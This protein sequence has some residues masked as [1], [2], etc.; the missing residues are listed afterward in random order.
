MPFQLSSD[1]VTRL[2]LVRYL[3]QHAEAVLK[4]PQPLCS[5]ALLSA[6][7]AIEMSLD[8]LAEAAN[9]STATGKN[10]ESYWK[11]LKS[12]A[13][14]VHLPLERQM[15]R[16]NR[17]RVDLKH[18]GLRPSSDQLIT[19]LHNGRA[20]IEDMCDKNF[21]ISLSDICLIDLIKNERL[22][23]MLRD[24]QQAIDRDDLREA[25][26]KAA[27]ALRYSSA[28]DSQSFPIEDN[29]LNRILR[30]IDDTFAEVF[31]R[32][33]VAISLVA[34]GIDLPSYNKFKRLTPLLGITASGKVDHVWPRTPS[35]KPEDARW[36]IDFVIDL[37][38][39][40]E[41]RRSEV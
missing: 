30:E 3:L 9:A 25:F 31:G 16:L 28:E 26:T 37:V 14:L 1:Q 12:S 36:C 23:D 39:R 7:D 2:A 11:G 32:M 10:F 40:V 22:R 19:H 41:G 13:P 35:D 6:H 38:L 18:H 33:D 15:I 4:N 27:I 5:L 34:L 24:A 17:A 20:F 8:V 21:A 29:E